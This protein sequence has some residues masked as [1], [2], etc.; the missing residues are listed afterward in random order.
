MNHRGAN[1]AIRGSRLCGF[2]SRVVLAL[3]ALHA[4]LIW[5]AHAE[6]CALPGASGA[7]HTHSV[8]RRHRCRAGPALVTR[9]RRAGAVAIDAVRA[10]RVPTRL[11]PRE[12]SGPEV[13]GT[14]KRSLYRTYA[15][16]SDDEHVA[17]VRSRNAAR[18]TSS[19][20]PELKP[21]SDPSLPSTF[22]TSPSR[23][24]SP[25]KATKAR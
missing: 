20:L 4:S 24:P 25:R 18:T 1:H 7:G 11:P 15:P 21:T 16:E 3:F 23:N 22:F 10:A 2:A 5:A 8:S 17:A 6:K 14:G 9:R 19:T 13:E 12:R